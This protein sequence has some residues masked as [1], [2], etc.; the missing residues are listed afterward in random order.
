MKH[1]HLLLNRK[2]DLYLQFPLSFLTMIVRSSLEKKLSKQQCAAMSNIAS[3]VNKIVL[4]SASA[5]C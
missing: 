4:L 5:D 1:M 2:T 3:S